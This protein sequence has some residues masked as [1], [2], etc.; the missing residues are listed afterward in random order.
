MASR[1]DFGPILHVDPDGDGG[2]VGIS[3]SYNPPR[4]CTNVISAA[5][6]ETASRLLDQ[7]N[8][9]KDVLFV[10]DYIRKLAALMLGK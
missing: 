10:L 4:R 5:D 9:S 8:R 6:R 2:C 1:W 7:M 3:K